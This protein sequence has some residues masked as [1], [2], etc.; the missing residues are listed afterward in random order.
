[1]NEKTAKHLARRRREKARRAKRGRRSPG[2]REAKRRPDP[3]RRALGLCAKGVAFVF[4]ATAALVGPW[5]WIPPPTSAFMLRASLVD[6]T[7]VDRRWVPYERISP[8]LALC[9]VASEDQK[10]P[11]HHGFDVDQILKAT[12]EARESP[13]GA[14]TIS[15]QV[16]KNLYLW[17][18]RS[19]VRK[20]IEAYLTVW[21]EQLWPKRRI[22][23]VYL[24]VA[25]FGPGVFGAG[26]ASERYF[27]KSASQLDLREAATLA[28]VLPNPKRLSAA[29]PTE[30]VRGRA[31][32]IRR[33]ALALGSRYVAGL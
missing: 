30:Y 20:G 19:L 18:G 32:E 14:S 28:A 31:E 3:G 24:N 22:L 17:P 21:I 13:R 26:A 27:G 6:G 16:A 4:V 25:E 15:Q 2:R 7:T 29:R 33:I 12:Q 11:D 23:E 5:R 1:V 10:F 8:H 9:V